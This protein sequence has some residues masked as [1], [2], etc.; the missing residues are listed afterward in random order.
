ME[1][2]ADNIDLNLMSNAKIKV[3][4]VG[5][6]GGNAVQE[7]INANL[8]GVQFICAN[9][10]VQALNKVN[11]P[12]TIQL[13]EQLTRGLG[14]GAKPDVGKNAAVES[15]NAIRT[16]LEGS[17][18]VF[19]TAGMGGGTGTG[20]APVI[21]QVAKEM[22]ALT[23]GVVTKPFSYEGTRRA[24][25]A[26]EGLDELAKYVDTLI[27]IPNDRLMGSLPKKTPLPM[28]FKKANEVLLNAVQ[29]ISDVIMREGLIN[30]DFADVRTT[31]QEKGLG[32]MG[33]GRA[34]G[35]NRAREATKQAIQ[36]PLLDNTSLESAK[37][38]LYNITAS[39][40]IT[41]EEMEEIGYM[42]HESAGPDPN[43]SIIAGVV[44]DEEMG[45]ELQ[46]TI[47]ATGID[48]VMPIE[49]EI[50]ASPANISP[51]RASDASHKEQAWSSGK[52]TSTQPPAQEDEVPQQKHFRRAMPESWQ[53]ERIGQSRYTRSREGYSSTYRHN[54]GKDIH[55]YSGD[56]YDI[57]SFLKKQID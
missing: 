4:G 52:Q 23:V 51:F 34:S 33:I 55:T 39:S 32:L 15:I 31:M 3:V 53:D 21:A 46:V 12:V 44:L 27:I 48:P 26:E 22:E 28:L 20:A 50:I 29:G 38:I 16:A 13:G 54:P 40:D 41:G 30:L 17:D 14:A 43:T 42:I 10:D 9:T 35:E 18:M 11:A 47:I 5:G 8:V 45:D 56:E 36:S 6:A 7:M 2:V 19:V 25:V 1:T 57:P 37:G 24:N 49:E